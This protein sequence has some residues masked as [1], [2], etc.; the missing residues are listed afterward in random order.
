MVLGLFD[1]ARRISLGKIKQNGGMKM[2]A[3]E[4]TN[5]ITSSLKKKLPALE[6]IHIDNLWFSGQKVNG[7]VLKKKNS[8]LYFSEDGT[9]PYSP[10]GGKECIR[11]Q[12]NN[13]RFLESVAGEDNYVKPGTAKTNVKRIRRIAD[14]YALHT[15]KKEYENG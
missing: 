13:V 15:L 7:Y 14:Q 11:Y 2:Y 1:S 8:D 3:F 5:I 9:L 4:V 10:I 6:I 12:L